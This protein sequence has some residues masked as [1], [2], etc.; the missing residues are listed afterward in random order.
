VSESAEPERDAPTLE[1]DR[2]RFRNA[3]GT[4]SSE[5]TLCSRAERIGLIGDWGV[6]FR[7]L[8][9]EASVTSGQ[10]RIFGLEL[11]A[12]LAQ[13]A[14]GVA[15][16]DP[17][18]PNS[19]SA[20][21][22]L[23]HAARLSHGSRTRAQNDAR[24]TLAD[25]GLTELTN[26]KISELPTYQRRALGLALAAVTRPA[27]LCLESPLRDLD[28]ASADYV[29]R[30]CLHA[31][32]RSRVIVSCAAAT[33][34]SPERAL[35]DQ[36]QELFAL[37][38]GSLAAHGTP[39]AVFSSSSRYLVTLS[40]ARDEEFARALGQAGCELTKQ[41]SSTVLAA[42]VAPGARLTRYL[43]ELPEASSTDLVLDAAL[44]SG[45]TVLEL[46]PLSYY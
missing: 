36:C 18:L 33:T 39:E 5:L 10:A 22:Y 1:L 11:R 40:G 20:R 43:L 37:E 13:N 31:S 27:A 42:F 17:T 2:A 34:P 19:F 41:S 21:E 32:E 30:L 9:G 15:L 24:H 44:D 38:R 12:A 35:L 16:C 7:A 28:A 8:S 23:E 14:L 26:K 29:A 45:M 6:L 4:P 25:F 46:E 3:D